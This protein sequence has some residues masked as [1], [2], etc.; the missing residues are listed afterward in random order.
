MRAFLSL[1]TFTLGVKGGS[2]LLSCHQISTTE[3]STVPTSS[4]RPVGTTHSQDRSNMTN[5]PHFPDACGSCYYFKSLLDDLSNAVSSVSTATK[6]KGQAFPVTSALSKPTF[7]QDMT[8]KPFSDSV[9]MENSEQRS[10]KSR[11]IKGVLRRFLIDT[12]T[13]PIS[14]EEM[15][16]WRLDRLLHNMSLFISP[17]N[18]YKPIY[19][20][21]PDAMV[22]SLGPQMDRIDSLYRKRGWFT[23]S[24]MAEVFIGITPTFFVETRY[25]FNCIPPNLLLSIESK[26]P[27]REWATKLFAR[28]PMIFKLSRYTLQKSVVKLNTDMWFVRAHPDFKKGNRLHYKNNAEYRAGMGGVMS[29]NA[30][31]GGVPPPGLDAGSTAARE[32]IQGSSEAFVGG[33]EAAK[34][35]GKAKPIDLRIFDILV[36]H[37]PRVPAPKTNPSQLGNKSAEKNPSSDWE[38][39]RRMR[40]VAMPLVEWVNGFSQA[41]LDVLN[42]VSQAYVLVILQEYP[43]VFQLMNPKGDSLF[44]YAD[45]DVVSLSLQNGVSTTSGRASAE[46]RVGPAPNDNLKDENPLEEDDMEA[47]GEDSE[48]IRNEIDNPPRATGAAQPCRDEKVQAREKKLH[49]ALRDDLLGI[50]DLAQGLDD[51]SQ[52]SEEFEDLS[53]DLLGFEDDSLPG[54]PLEEEEMQDKE[55]ISSK[56]KRRHHL[57]NNETADGDKNNSDTHHFQGP[58]DVPIASLNLNELYVRRLPPEIA[59]RSLSNFNNTTTPTPEL[60]ELVASFLAPPPS[61][62]GERDN[63][64]LRCQQKYR[65]GS[66]TIGVKGKEGSAAL[67]VPSNPPP[68]LWRWVRIQGIYLAL[69]PAQRQAIRSTYSGLVRFLR[70]HGELFEVSEDML[71]V[72]AHDPQGVLAPIVP[73]QKH[74]R[75]Q[76]RVVLPKSFDENTNA[77]AA[78]IGEEERQKYKAILGDSQI[79]AT[80]RQLILLDPHNPLLHRDVLYDEISQLLPYNCAIKKSTMMQRLPPILKASLGKGAISHLISHPNDYFTVFEEDGVTMMQR[81]NLQPPTGSPSPGLS[82]EDS[83]EALRAAV[84]LCGATVF[85]LTRLHLSKPAVEGLKRHFGS[86]YTAVKAYPQYFKIS[87][88]PTGKRSEALV[89]IVE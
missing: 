64:F 39:V 31:T 85:A 32:A 81:K 25:I 44:L 67:Q 48:G 82:A 75:F 78:L 79:P 19:L 69:S 5:K 27:R 58:Q 2:Y 62:A 49:Q 40:Y 41:E 13:P 42:T 65:Q 83:V 43:L 17:C 71:H 30:P 20:L 50:D 54:D 53:G 36:S 18:F 29:R 47:W 46:D 72:I 89:M 1:K 87:E 51:D 9:K 60:V 33:K 34:M 84:P 74:F 8:K 38:A 57:L 7:L 37:L 66:T 35:A 16:R 80:R 28:Y 23:P 61:L 59:P 52:E 15:I 86:V 88:N 11:W 73:T 22:T 77:T 14:Q 10:D 12:S 63:F 45:R 70:L 26:Y 76:Q 21:P 3:R 24:E 6:E 55:A 68:R 56:P 4:S